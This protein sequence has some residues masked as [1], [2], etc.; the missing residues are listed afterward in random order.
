MSLTD[1]QKVFVLSSVMK[2]EDK[3]QVEKA[4]AKDL[5][6]KKN[7]V[8]RDEI[9]KW[10]DNPHMYDYPK[11]DYLSK[12]DQNQYKSKIK[13]M[14]EYANV[15]RESKVQVIERVL[16]NLGPSSQ[17]VIPI[18][19]LSQKPLPGT[20]NI[21]FLEAGEL[22]KKWIGDLALDLSMMC[23]RVITTPPSEKY[24]ALIEEMCVFRELRNYEGIGL[25]PNAARLLSD[26]P[27]D[28]DEEKYR[29]TFGI[30]E[31]YMLHLLK[32]YNNNRDKFTFYFALENEQKHGFVIYETRIK[33]QEVHLFI[34]IICVEEKTRGIGRGLMALV[35][36]HALRK[37]R[38]HMAKGVY[39]ELESIDAPETF[40]FYYSIGF[41]LRTKF[42]TAFWS[43]TNMI[44]GNLLEKENLLS[45]GR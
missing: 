45:L 32:K 23:V 17:M 5:A 43:N 18:T 42:T 37:G 22:E 9:E 44:T 27:F 28:F 13:A 38:E 8:K 7:V 34:H 40:V 11:T 4:M 31:D 12:K 10:M 14:K 26:C 39:I 21:T 3:K 19:P 36:E 1:L 2:G 25:H 20:K 15:L 29:S 41:N 33:N 30:G 6:K 35:Q 16:L 24:Q